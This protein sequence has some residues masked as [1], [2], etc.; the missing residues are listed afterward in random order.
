MAPG[1]SINGTPHDRE[2]DDDSDNDDSILDSVLYLETQ[3]SQE[4][5]GE[6]ALG[7]LEAQS[8]ALSDTEK[9]MFRHLIMC[10][11]NV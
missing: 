3:Y 10:C 8:S 7:M 9:G 11:N 5:S 1:N 4:D 2:Q 6:D